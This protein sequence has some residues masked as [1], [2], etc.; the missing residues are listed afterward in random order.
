[1]TE[2]KFKAVFVNVQPQHNVDIPWFW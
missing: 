1:L 2:N